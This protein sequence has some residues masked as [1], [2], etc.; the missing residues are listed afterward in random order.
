MKVEDFPIYPA[1][2]RRWAVVLSNQ[3]KSTNFPVTTLLILLSTFAFGVQSFGTVMLDAPS[4]RH[5]TSFLYLEGS[6]VVYLLSPFWHRGVAH[7]GANMVILFALGP[8]ERHF[9]RNQYWLLCVSLGV[10]SLLSGY[11]VLY[12]FA[13]TSR[14]AFYGISGIAFGLAGFALFRGAQ[15]WDELIEI[16]FIGMIIGIA[17]AISVI[18]NL[19]TSLP[20]SPI[21]VN[22]GHLVGF[23]LGVVVAQLVRE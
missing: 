5:F 13:G 16:D 8:Q 12:A 10:L 18:Q 11:A 19:A 14:I 9:Q 4:V 21:G 17:A 7:Y 20:Q 22:G 2:Y 23:I 6:S 15:N 1:D 3:Y